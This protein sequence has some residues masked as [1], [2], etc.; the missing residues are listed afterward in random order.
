MENTSTSVALVDR[1]FVPQ[2]RW[3]WEYV[4]PAALARSADADQMP[5]WY[6]PPQP[7]VSLWQQQ[8]AQGM[9]RLPKRLG[10][11]AVLW[12]L[13]SL[14]SAGFGLLVLLGGVTLAWVVPVLVP[15]QRIKAAL[16]GAQLNRDAQFAQVQQ[17]QHDWQARI[18]A[19]DEHER[20]RHA[21]ALLWFPL[22]LQSG[23]S[24][25]DV[26]GGT[27]D[28]W[29][30]LVTTLGCSLLRSG[31]AVVLVD[32]SEQYIGGALATFAS[33][34][35]AEVTQ[36]DLPVESSRLNVIGG[37]SAEELSEL[38][39]ESVHS[40]RPSTDGADL[41]AL[42][43]ELLAAVATR[44]D[45]PPTFARLVAGLKALRRIYE[46]T[47]DGPLTVLEATRLT[48][49][50]DTIGQADRVQHELQFLT[51]VLDLLAK[52]DGNTVGNTTPVG[53]APSLWPGNG[54]TIVN[55]FSSHQRRKDF[56]DRVLFHRLLH[57][58][59]NRRPQASD[60]VMIVAGADHIGRESLEAM[61]RQARRVG[62][63]LILLLER[64]RGELQELLGSSDSAS[65]I[66]R[67][68]NT[69][70]SA[71]AAEFIGRGHKFVLN[72]VTNQVGK[73]FTEGTAES[74]GTQEGESHTSG[75]AK[76]RTQN[77]TA[78]A[79]L[80][81]RYAGKS[82]GTSTSESYT[83]SRS[84]TWQET[85]SQSVSDS[86]TDGTVTARVYEFAV[87]P[88]EIQSLPPTAFVLVEAG[89]SGRRVVLGDCNPGITLLDRVGTTPQLPGR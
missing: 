52:E 15:S 16:R 26:F 75:H 80:F 53:K 2:E 65:I 50:V 58:L 29:A 13:C 30:S 74:R 9:A 19:H 59:R 12:I 21:A 28:G 38:L 6:E 18:D 61:T 82:L 79:G 10:I 68:G 4:E 14:A 49:Y 51:S 56:L 34:R 8:R 67:L 37:I 39:A 23:P 71:A 73:T 25:V 66:M 22:Q 81:S 86:T 60:D 48:S 63:R 32:L 44:L 11:V 84:R 3:G 40:M 62:V 54:L 43:A 89:L 20:Q 42:H 27:G 76:N 47:D 45:A 77:W 69:Q 83:E 72:Q 64:L 87:E 24:R 17:A 85:V 35:G 55:T 70:D 7:D 46:V 36:V 1:L 33:A 78:G 41:R 57:E 31:N 88:T 5:V